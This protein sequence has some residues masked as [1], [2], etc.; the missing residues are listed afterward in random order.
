M[1]YVYDELGLDTPAALPAE[2]AALPRQ[3][4]ETTHRYSLDEFG[5]DPWRSRSARAGLFDH[6]GWDAGEHARQRDHGSGE[7]AR[8]GTT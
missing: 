4:H 6:Y 1:R 2:I 5:L 7:L 8:R 3:G